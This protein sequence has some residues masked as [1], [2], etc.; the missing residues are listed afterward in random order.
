MLARRCASPLW[1]R[2]RGRLRRACPGFYKFTVE[3][4]TAG[5][6]SATGDIMPYM[7][8]TDEL[9]LEMAEAHRMAKVAVS[10][11]AAS[12]SSS[13]SSPSASAPSG[14]APPPGHKIGVD[15]LQPGE[16]GFRNPVVNVALV[17]GNTS[18][19][20]KAREASAAQQQKEDRARLLTDKR[21]KEA[22]A[23]AAGGSA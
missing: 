8:P 11:E 17:V 21:E 9:R 3:F 5:I 7:A 22:A 13:S 23:A 2:R 12:P 1:S 16:D 10:A 4:T 6:N 19:A 18:V 14:G 20:A 15:G